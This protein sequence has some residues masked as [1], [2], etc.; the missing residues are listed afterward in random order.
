MSQDEQRFQ[1]FLTRIRPHRVA[2]FVNMA[3]PNWYESSFGVIEFLTKLWGGS[4]SVIIP[5]DGKT[6]DEEFWAILSSH[7]PD[8]FYRY[9]P[10]GADLK[11][12]APEEFERLLSENVKQ[13]ARENNVP[14]DQIRGL[15]EKDLLKAAINGW[16]VSEEL[17]EE[18]LIRLAPFHFEKQPLHGMPNRLLKI[19]VFSKGSKPHYPLT[20]VM[21]V[22]RA[23]NQRTQVTQLGV[24]DASDAE[25]APPRLWLAATIG[26]GDDEYFRELIEQQINP[27]WTTV[28]ELHSLNTIIKSGIRPWGHTLDSFPLGMTTAALTSVRIGVARRFELPTIVVVGSSLKDFC[29]YFDLY[30]QQGRALWLPPWFLPKDG[31][32]PDRLMTAIHEAEEASRPD[33]NEQL[34]LVSYSA[35]EDELTKLQEIIRA[36]IFRT[37]VNIQPI[38]RDLVAIQVKHPSRVYAD[39]DLGNITTHMLLNNNLPGSFESPVPRTL[40]PASPLS[41]R[42]I[43]DITF[44]QHLVPRHPI[45]GKI[46]INGSNVGDARAGAECVSYMCPGVAVFGDHMETNILRPSVHVPDAEEIFRVILDDCG[47]QAKT[48]DKGRYEAVAVQKFGDLEKAGYAFWSDKH[49]ILL[50]KYLDNSDS[51]E[52][53]VD[54]G[55]RLKDSR[56]YLDF[57]SMHKILGSDNLTRQI[58]DEYIERGVFYRGFIFLCENCSD[59]AWHSIAD[60]DQM[61]TC[62]RCGLKQQY[63]FA[64]WKMPNEPSWF[65]KLDEMIYLM[66]KHNGHVPLLT[67]NKLRLGS[68]ESFLFRPEVRLTRKGSSSMFLETDIC[69][70]TDGKL[71]IGEAKSNNSL[72]GSKLTPMQTAERY[73]DLALEM[74]ATIVVF[75]TSAV[76]W[77]QPSRD[78]MHMAFE[79]HP[80]INVLKWT[81]ATLYG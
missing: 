14:E 43:V 73:R 38:T 74:G 78:A 15:L 55:V 45:L 3:D 63:K 18:I 39:G 67:L 70:V 34:V 50:Q 11:A 51:Q 48:S 49:R 20:A 1:S 80:H 79:K 68:K 59:A 19:Q 21:D 32:Y 8:V 2:V 7:D 5:T 13:W 35:G 81:S 76:A 36:R 10:T 30:W 28:D 42:W 57:Q 77:D 12:R 31:E 46:V 66:L 65:Y 40:N 47:Y 23:G 52:G 9:Q 54:Q 60:V 41:H 64:S 4:H 71:C 56:R 16:T 69:C 61:F 17:Q 72:E 24:N 22:L 33:H 75:S 37:S 58:I 27:I 62:R 53:V 6:I 29:L 26:C 25:I 44:M